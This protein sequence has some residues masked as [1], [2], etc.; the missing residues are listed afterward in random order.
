MKIKTQQQ[1]TWDTLKSVWQEIYNLGA[2]TNTS[3]RAEIKD[4]MIQLKKLE[5]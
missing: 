1:N 4:L 3:E 2:Y 5:K